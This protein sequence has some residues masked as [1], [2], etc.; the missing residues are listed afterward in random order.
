MSENY[1]QPESSKAGSLTGWLVA[2]VVLVNFFV[3]SLVG[4]FLYQSRINLE[5][6]NEIRTQNMAAVLEDSLAETFGMGSTK[7]SS[8]FALEGIF[9]SF[10]SLRVFGLQILTV[11]CFMASVL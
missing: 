4:L 9:H 7:K 11:M 6:R 2:R 3:F 8:I 5:K 1:S 10:H